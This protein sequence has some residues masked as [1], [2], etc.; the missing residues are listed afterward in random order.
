LTAL[1]W[2]LPFK[3]LNIMVVVLKSIYGKNIPMSKAYLQ[4][5]AAESPARSKTIELK[6]P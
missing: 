6:N 2:H 1:S 4:L 5:F 3:A